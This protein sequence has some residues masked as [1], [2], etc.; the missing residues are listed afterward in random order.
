MVI[1]R[2]KENLQIVFSFCSYFLLNKTISPCLMRGDLERGL[3]LVPLVD[4]AGAVLEHHGDHGI[5][6]LGSRVSVLV[7]LTDHARR[8]V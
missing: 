3:V 7:R 8:M 5:V 6:T 2:A 1:K 4:E